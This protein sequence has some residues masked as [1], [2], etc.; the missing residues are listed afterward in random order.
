MHI[1]VLQD[2]PNLQRLSSFKS[3][4]PSRPILAGHESRTAEEHD[5]GTRNG[6]WLIL[7]LAVEGHH[8]LAAFPCAC[9]T[10]HLP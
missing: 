1:H 5:G 9:S 3:F 2:C 7:I 4:P 8:E 10:K 6:K